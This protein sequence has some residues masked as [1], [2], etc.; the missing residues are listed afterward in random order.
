MDSEWT[1]VFAVSSTFSDCMT[2]NNI[3]IELVDDSMSIAML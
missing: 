1:L 2:R 3:D